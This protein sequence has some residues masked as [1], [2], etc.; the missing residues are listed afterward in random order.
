MRNHPK[1]LFATVIAL[2][3]IVSPF[4]VAAGEGDPLRGGARNADIPGS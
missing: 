1:W 4:A 2:A 3:L